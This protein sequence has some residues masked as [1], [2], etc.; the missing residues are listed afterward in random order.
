[1]RAASSSAKLVAM[2]EA[3]V[4]R[5][6]A[7][8]ESTMIHLRLPRSAMRAS[9]IDT[10]P[11]SSEK[12]RPFIRPSWVSLSRNSF[13]IGSM[14]IEITTLSTEHMKPTTASATST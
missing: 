10:S 3:P 2:P 7:I 11:P 5:V 1:M 9:G 4:M 8:N 6:Q 12:A 13:L 14:N